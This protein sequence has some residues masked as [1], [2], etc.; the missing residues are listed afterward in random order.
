M[1]KMSG[2][3]KKKKRVKVAFV[4]PGQGSQV[5]G[6]GKSFYDVLPWA[7]EAYGAADEIL[8]YGLSKIA[9]EGP[10]EELNRTENT[11]PALLVASLIALG[12]LKASFPLEPVMMA[13]HSLGEYTA[14]VASGALQFTDAVSLVHK[15]GRYMQEAVP[16]GTGGM[17]AVLGLD[18]ASV[19]KVCKEASDGESVVVP[20]NINSPVQVVVSGSIDAVERVYALAKD[21]GAKRVVPLKVSAPSHSPLMA[22]AAARFAKELESIEFSKPNVPIVTNVEAE[23]STDPSVFPDLL[24]RQLTSPVR[25]VETIMK[26]KSEGVEAIM[27]IGPGT[28]LTGLVRRIDKDMQI[29]NLASVSDLGEL[30]KVF[31]QAPDRADKS[32]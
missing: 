4:F 17:A 20:A 14:L 16:D 18:V 2:S 10:P 24:T 31:G 19:E 30:L 13:G 5:V 7:K 23:P 29:Y 22:P 25:W 1:G 21:A 9:L 8:E 27:E 11:Q 12:A 15:R 26:M 32:W 6:M 28:V 3:K